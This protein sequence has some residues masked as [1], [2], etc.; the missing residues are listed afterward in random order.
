V[1]VRVSAA[2]E[3][4]SEKPNE[5]WYAC[6][7]GAVAV[8][9][10]VTVRPGIESG[11]I[12]GTPWYVRQLGSHLVAAM[13][14]SPASLADALAASISDV[15][16]QHADTCDLGT[17]GAPSAAVAAVRVIDGNVEWLAL[18]DVTIVLETR[19]DL[20]VITDNRVAP[21]VAGL[22]AGTPNLGERIGEARVAHRNREG[23]YWVAA[24]DPSAAAHA[25]TGSLPVADLRR[26]MVL[27]DGAARLVDVFG[28]KWQD[29]VEAGPAQTIQEVRAL[30]AEDPACTRWPRMKPRDDATAV[31]WVLARRASAASEP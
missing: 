8:L 14:N 6:L 11:C 22:D 13:T 29:A 9:D 27:T 10:G 21:S 5:D 25:L 7:P 31:L 24:E 30:E 1:T 26:L 16:A 2:S 17:I 28:S 15:A 19:T 3:P 18:A 23:G 20:A 12:H 4:G